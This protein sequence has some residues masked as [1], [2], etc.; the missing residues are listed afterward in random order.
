MYL[1]EYGAQHWS[2]ID[3]LEHFEL[4]A[5]NK[6]VNVFNGQFAEENSRPIII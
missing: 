3:N 2:L 1:R 6:A 5:T 4:S